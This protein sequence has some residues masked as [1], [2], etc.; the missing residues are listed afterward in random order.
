MQSLKVFNKLEDLRKIAKVTCDDSTI[1]TMLINLISE[2]FEES[3]TATENDALDK[4]QT[5]IE[6]LK[7][8]AAKKAA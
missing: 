8:C 5:E 7:R 6:F 1:S 3:N 2:L 4:I